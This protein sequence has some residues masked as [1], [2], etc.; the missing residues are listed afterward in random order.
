MTSICT[1][2][3]VLY[4]KNWPTL[5]KQV[6]RKDIIPDSFKEAQKILEICK[7]GFEFLDIFIRE[8]HPIFSTTLVVTENIP[9]FRNLLLNIYYNFPIRYDMQAYIL[10]LFCSLMHIVHIYII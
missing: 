6:C 3:I 7:D 9:K 1:R 2:K 4:I 8:L 10:Y 5:A